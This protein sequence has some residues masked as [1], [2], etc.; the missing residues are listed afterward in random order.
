MAFDARRL[1]TRFEVPFFLFQGA[2]DV[3]TLTGPA[4]EYFADVEAP[5]KGLALIE[6]ASHFCAFA[7]PD[8]FLT[9]LLTRVRPLATGSCGAL[10]T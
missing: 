4:E 10:Q 9:E 1:G 7:R 6:D 8:R 3:I 2:G 5:T